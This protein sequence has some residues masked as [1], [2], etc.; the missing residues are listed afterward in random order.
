M[1]ARIVIPLLVIIALSDI[2][3]YKHFNLYRLKK[4]WKLIY[5]IPTIIIVAYTIWMASLSNF[6]TDNLT[7]Q[8]TY[9]ILLGIFVLPKVV[10]MLFTLFLQILSH[11]VFNINN[12][13]INLLGGL[14]AL[15]TV[16]IY[17]YGFT[18]G[19]TKVVTRHINLTFNNLPASFNSYKIVHISDMHIGT[20]N[21]WRKKILL[22]ELD[23]IEAAKPDIICFTGDLE[24]VQAKEL[25]PFIS[26][27][28]KRLPNVIAVRG[29]H[30]YG[31]Y[32]LKASTLAKKKQT[33]NLQ[34]IIEDSLHWRLLKNEHIPLY[35]ENKQLKAKNDSI[36]IIGT[37]YDSNNN[38]M[39]NLAD[40]KKAT[41]GMKKGVFSIM[42][43]HD[44]S[45][46]KRSVLPKTHADLTLSGH[47]HGGQMQ[48]F[49]LRPTSI[50]GL[51]DKGVYKKNNRYL[52]VTTGLGGLIPLRIN[53][54]NEITIITLHSSH[55]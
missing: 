54:P 45:A 30:D 5:C 34:S 39:L 6:T 47:T 55:Y 28:K 18:F 14:S 51:E 12:T 52:Y 7:L 35:K 36:Y 40:Y 25:I 24:N 43:Q 48:L 22:S 13:Y 29:N 46:W 33:D 42:L 32:M 20:F 23:T 50:F 37:E 1:I 38:K 21:G 49:G 19:I 44:P 27:L 2:Y 26:L 4:S 41:K 11:Y 3:V 31:N 16:I 9:F 10:F 8:N 17:I 53:M 15:A